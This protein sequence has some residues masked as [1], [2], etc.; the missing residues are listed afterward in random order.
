MT[1]SEY[2]VVDM[3]NMNRYSI[4]EADLEN[5][6]ELYLIRKLNCRG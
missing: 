1:Y 5:E 6:F 4:L 2:L 3:S